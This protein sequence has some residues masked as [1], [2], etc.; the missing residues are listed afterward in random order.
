MFKSLPVGLAALTYTQGIKVNSIS[1]NLA[2]QKFRPLDG[3]VPWHK[4]VSQ[5]TWVKPDW[6]VGYFIPNFGVDSDVV[7]T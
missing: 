7:D 2:Q 6:D 5:A 4:E 1:N 3:T